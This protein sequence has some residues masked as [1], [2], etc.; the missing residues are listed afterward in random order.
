[1]KR[2]IQGL[3]GGLLAA[4]LLLGGAVGALADERAVPGTAEVYVD[5]EQSGL[6][7]YVI[8]GSS[9]YP[10]REIGDAVGFD[11]DWDA[12]AQRVLIDTAPLWHR[13]SGRPRAC[14]RCRSAWP[15]R[16]VSC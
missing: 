7:G 9:Y 1:M 3:W 6:K 11:V 5:G 8:N 15:A 12:E 4:A 16:F 13:S 14:A 10:I 2:L